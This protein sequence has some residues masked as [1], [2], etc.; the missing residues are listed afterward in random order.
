MPFLNQE[1]HHFTQEEEKSIQS[2]I[3]KLKTALTSKLANLTPEERKQ[4]GSVNEQNKLIINKVRDY[5]ENQPNL[6]S[7]DVDWQE[8]INDHNS[9]S[10]LQTAIDQL[11]E[12]V[13]GMK[14]AKILHDWDNYKAALI[15]YNYTQYKNNSGANGFTTKVSE[16]KQF[17][18]RTGTSNSNPKPKDDNNKE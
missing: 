15:D 13:K 7:P 2:A 17:F 10:F 4:Y 1:N 12:L 9:R 14:N 18:S 3:T 8:Y 16:L 11:S 6:A 5:Q